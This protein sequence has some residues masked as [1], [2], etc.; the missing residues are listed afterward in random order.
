MNKLFDL[1]TNFSNDSKSFNGD[2]IRGNGKTCD[3]KR[4]I[5]SF[6]KVEVSGAIQLNLTLSS[7][8]TS[9]KVIA[10]ENI[11]PLI[12]TEV[13]GDVLRIYSDG[14]YTTKTQPVLNLSAPEVLKVSSSGS[15]DVII[16]HVAQEQ[17]SISTSGSG[18][19]TVTGKAH[20]TKLRVSGS[21]SIRAVALDTEDLDAKVSGSGSV[22]ATA[23]SNAV[24]QVSGSGS[25][26]V[27]GN[28]GSVHSKRS[29]SGSIHMR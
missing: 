3:Q 13:T 26:Q 2:S 15:S 7:E 10:D 28:P 18:D 6:K 25:I 23:K 20:N 11:L 22:K 8:T 17:I 21:A 16:T 24:L 9:A 14:L 5:G 12:L 27:W 1:I 19:I 4:D 29:G